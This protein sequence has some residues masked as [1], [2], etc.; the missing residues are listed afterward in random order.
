MLIKSCGSFNHKIQKQDNIKATYDL[1]EFPKTFNTKGNGNFESD[2]FIFQS[3]IDD[4]IT[5]NTFE[6]LKIVTAK[7]SSNDKDILNIIN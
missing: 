6:E 2:F 3:K 1:S 5:L 4:I 7:I